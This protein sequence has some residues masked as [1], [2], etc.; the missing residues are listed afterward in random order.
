MAVLS[1]FQRPMVKFDP[2]IKAHRKM[3]VDAMNNKSLG[4]LPVQFYVDGEAYD[5]FQQIQKSVS[6]YF[7]RREFT[8]KQVEQ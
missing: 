4:G 3:V 1:K 8:S 6:E 2:A 5:L 7:L